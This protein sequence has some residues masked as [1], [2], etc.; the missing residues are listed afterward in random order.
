MMTFPSGEFNSFFFLKQNQQVAAAAAQINEINK[1]LE[2]KD[3]LINSTRIQLAKAEE[4][5][6]EINAEHDSVLQKLAQAVRFFSD[7]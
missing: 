2:D 7:M 1:R 4:N 3:D 5:I 6:S